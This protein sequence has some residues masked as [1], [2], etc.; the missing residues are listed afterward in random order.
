MISQKVLWH[1]MMAMHILLATTAF[2]EETVALSPDAGAAPPAGE[3]LP[4]KDAAA[5]G[6]KPTA[7]A[8]INITQN[9]FSNWA[10]GGTDSLSWQANVMMG[11]TDMQE[12]FTWATTGKFVYGQAK[13]GDMDYRK[14][15]DE[16]RLESVLTYSLPWIVKPYAAILGQTQFAEGYQY[17]DEARTA[18]SNFMDPGYL[19]ESLGVGYGDEEIKTRLGFAVKETYTR[20]HPV[21]YTDDPKTAEIERS[22]VEPG[23]ESVTDIKLA[24][25][26]LLVFT[27]QLNIFSNTKTMAEVVARWENMLNANVAKYITVS[28]HLILYYDKTQSSRRQLNQTMAAGLT[29]TLF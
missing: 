16:I 7:V 4:A 14:S 15:A 8:N 9:A 23:L 12:A 11:L 5:Y 17:A 10:A 6:M 26:E 20:D 3:A 22:K 1:G 25:S 21:P 27:S 13:V 29:Y 28:F 19:T 2:A 18:I 24:L